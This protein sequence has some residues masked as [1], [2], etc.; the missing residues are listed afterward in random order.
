MFPLSTV[1]FNRV[2]EVILK[3]CV[4]GTKGLVYGDKHQ[5]LA[6]ADDMVLMARSKKGIEHILKILEDMV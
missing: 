3:E 6:Y 2:K 4:V 5:Y 1:I